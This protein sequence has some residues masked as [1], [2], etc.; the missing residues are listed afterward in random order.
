MSTPNVLVVSGNKFHAY[1]LARGIQQAGWLKYFITGI[2]DKSETGLPVEKIVQVPLPSHLMNALAL[3][4]SATIQAWSYNIG[5]NWFDQVASRYATQ[6]NVY[7]VFNHHGLQGI[8]QAKKHEA[9]TIVER[10]AAH[11]IYQ[12]QL[13]QEEYAQFG[14]RYPSTYEHLIAKQVQEFAEADYI[15]VASDFVKR[16]MLQA[17]LPVAKLRQ[18]YLGFDP[19][20]FYPGKK[21]DEIFRV[22]FVG[23]ISLQK[24]VQYLLEG[25]KRAKLPP[26]RVELLLV[27]DQFPD[28]QSFLPRYEGLYRHQRFVPHTELVHLYQ[29]SSVFILPSLQ[30]GFGMVVY[31]A[32][33][34]GLP[35][36]ITENVG[37]TVRNG[38]D[39]FIIPIRDPDA[40]AVKLQYLF[41]HQNECL[42][43]GQSVCNY[44]QQFTW[45]NYQQSVI[46]N[47]KEIFA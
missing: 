33:A 2:Y 31:E 20:N 41:E 47:Y 22:I 19:R 16:T 9:I 1:H 25:F 8:R 45:E 26:T 42:Q 30:D 23:A 6:G 3:L 5:D 32:A 14:L 29:N 10:S 7:H 21:Q 4:P 13:L 27:G 11:P 15:F 34:C 28:A 43:M 17:G 36:I 39:G 35:V 38:Q 40:I 24:G 46:N 18:N 44:V 37:A 12:N